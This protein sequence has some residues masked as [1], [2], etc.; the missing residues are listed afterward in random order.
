MATKFEEAF[1]KMTPAQRKKAT[2]A[3]SDMMGMPAK[4][5][6]SNNSKKGNNFFMGRGRS[7]LNKSGSGGGGAGKSSTPSGISYD[8]FLNMP[9]TQKYQT[10]DDILNDQSI[11]VPNYLDG[12][13]TTKLLY[14]LGMDNKPE[15]V[16]DNQIDKMKGNNLFRTVYDVDN[17][18]PYAQDIIDQIKRGD[19]TQLSGSGGSVH[20][21][22]LYFARDFTGS[23]IYGHGHSNPQMIRAKLKQNANIA[24]E[25]DLRRWMGQDQNFPKGRYKGSD[26]LSMYAL[27]RGADGWYDAKTGYTMILNRGALAVSS[28]NKIVDYDT[29]SWKTANNAN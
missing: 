18:P 20:G 10:I 6:K 21:R 29:Y 9:A 22:A 19:Y 25:E 14:A 23:A 26:A 2:A 1:S 8:Q 5:K 12:S 17:P 15:I 13:P 3:I 7:K 16:S 11:A 27:S 4:K 24:R 28:T